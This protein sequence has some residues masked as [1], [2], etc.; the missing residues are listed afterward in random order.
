MA[1]EITADGHWFDRITGAWMWCGMLHKKFED[2][3]RPRCTAQLADKRVPLPISPEDE[4]PEA[5]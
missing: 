1:L 5:A 2:S 3:N 4:P